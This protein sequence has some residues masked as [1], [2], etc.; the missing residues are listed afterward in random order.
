VIPFEN[1][2]VLVPVRVNRLDDVLRAR[3][4]EDV[5][6]YPGEADPAEPLYGPKKDWPGEDLTRLYAVSK[7]N[8]RLAFSHVAHQPPNQRVSLRE[9]SEVV[10][11][12]GNDPNLNRISGVLNGLTGNSR[13][14]RGRES[15]VWP[16]FY[17]PNG[18]TG[19]FEYWMDAATAEKFREIERF[20]HP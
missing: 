8:M 14:I 13:K 20:F 11:G 12:E 18:E 2:V 9:L 17:D 5:G 6:A 19:G 16:I 15:G 10:F 3:D 7:L 4:G 1:D